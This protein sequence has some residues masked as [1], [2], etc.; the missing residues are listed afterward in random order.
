MNSIEATMMLPLGDVVL[1]G[2][3]LVR[4]VIPVGRRMHAQVQ[5]G[6]LSRQHFA[7]HHPP[8]PTCDCR[9]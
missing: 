6:K 9:A 7:A 8:L 4:I 1:A 2:L 3:K 5:I